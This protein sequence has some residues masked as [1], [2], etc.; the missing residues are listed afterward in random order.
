MGLG[1]SSEEKEEGR[2]GETCREAVPSE[3][4]H[5]ADKNPKKAEEKEQLSHRTEGTSLGRQGEEKAQKLHCIVGL[6]LSR[7]PSDYRS[8]HLG[9]WEQQPP[10][11]SLDSL[12]SLLLF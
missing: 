2:L 4:V 3:E 12:R 8:L 11:G 7:C 10:G 5:E 6:T 1:S 9:H